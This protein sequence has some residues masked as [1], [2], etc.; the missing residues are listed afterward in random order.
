MNYETVTKIYVNANISS[1]LHIQ[2][3]LEKDALV[4]AMWSVSMHNMHFK[5]LLNPLG[6]A[7]YNVQTF[8]CHAVLISH[9][10][11]HG[12]NNSFQIPLL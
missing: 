6:I 12:F 2:S 4:C 10:R 1:Q 7:G 9:T 11:Q 3:D 8:F 5:S